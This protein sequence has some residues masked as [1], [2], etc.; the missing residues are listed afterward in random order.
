[1]K[2]VLFV[3]SILFS[4]ISFTQENA[5]NNWYFGNRCGISFNTGV[6]LALTDG[7]LDQQ[8]GVCSISNQQGELLFYSDGRTIWDKNHNAMPNSDGDLDGHYSSTQS[9][10]IAP[11][12]MDNTKFYIFTVDELG[13]SNGLKY[14]TVDMTLPG[15]GTIAN[16]LGD[17]VNTEKNI[18]LASPVVEKIT[19]VLK[20]NNI[21]YWVIAHAWG[22][23][24]FYV[25]EVTTSGVNTTPWVYNIGEDF[26]GNTINTVGYMKSTL[27]G[28]KI[29]L[30]NRTY[31]HINLFDFNK[32][33]G[34]VS[35]PVNIIPLNSLIYGLEF[36]YDN[37]YLFIAGET[38]ISKY[39]LTDQTQVNLSF[40]D[41]S[42][43]DPFASAV[44]AL[45]IAPNGNVY[46][47]VRYNEY[48]SMID[49][50]YTFVRSNEGEF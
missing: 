37:Q 1:M 27:N 4:L 19:I 43:F 46:V 34:E 44:R 23:N 24:T 12:L 31:G 41:N 38:T 49:P 33:T 16:P 28:D 17:V 13:G 29:A 3:L 15:N 8:E 10:I 2:K 11:N 50:D 36:S 21:D 30:V 18:A 32:L 22:N 26:S 5:G 7:V 47:S 14:S 48:L 39:N 45:Q 40:D 42:I 20:S 6:P 25:F 9:A 35:N